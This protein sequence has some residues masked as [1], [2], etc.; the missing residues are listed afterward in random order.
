MNA[1]PPHGYWSLMQ[2]RSQSSLNRSKSEFFSRSL[3][4]CGLHVSIINSQKREGEGS[5]GPFEAK[6]SSS[7]FASRDKSSCEFAFYQRYWK[8]PGQYFQ[9][10]SEICVNQL[11][12]ETL[13][14]PSGVN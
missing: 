1:T 4:G 5:S 12:Q 2:G 7:E 13:V 6:C 3:N 9:A 11:G 14:Y 10:A 8:L